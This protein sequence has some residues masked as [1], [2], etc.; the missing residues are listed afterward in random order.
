MTE[1]DAGACDREVA[2]TC[3]LNEMRV[4]LCA[5]CARA[6][7]DGGAAKRVKTHA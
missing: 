1:C 3:E 5:K 7:C 4:D 2:Y 6:E